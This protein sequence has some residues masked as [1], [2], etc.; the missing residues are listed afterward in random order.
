MRTLRVKSTC[1]FAHVVGLRDVAHAGDLA[2]LL[3]ERHQRVA[4][5][6]HHQHDDAELDEQRARLLGGD[7]VAVG[8]AARDVRHLR[9]LRP[10]AT[11]R[12]S[13]TAPPI[14]PIDVDGAP[15]NLDAMMPTKNTSGDRRQHPAPCAGSRARCRGALVG[16]RG[17][18]GGHRCGSVAVRPWRRRGRHLTTGGVSN[19]WYGAGEGTVHSSVVGAF[20]GLGR[21]LRAVAASTHLITAH[22]KM[23]LRE[24]EAERADRRDHVPVGELLRVVGN[25]ARHAGEAEEVHREERD[26]E[27]DRST[28]RSAACRASRRTSCRSTSAASSRRRRRTRTGCPRPS[29]SGSARRRSR[30]PGAGCRSA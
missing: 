1:V 28:T 26:V 7:A 18:V 2:D 30:C 22:R 19:V 5:A 21:R 3:V 24:A 25:A 27:G 20:P 11:T 16:R 4:E 13:S 10:M 9:R 12:N 6:E 17:E 8:G 29:R 14:T 15:R 23:Q